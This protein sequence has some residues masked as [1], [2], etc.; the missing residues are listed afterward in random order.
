MLEK[1]FPDAYIG[2]E[3]GW[4]VGNGPDGYVQAEDH[5]N[6]TQTERDDQESFFSETQNT[7]YNTPTNKIPPRRKREKSETSMAYGRRS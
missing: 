1:I 2:T 7:G 3:D 6:D 5:V 4:A